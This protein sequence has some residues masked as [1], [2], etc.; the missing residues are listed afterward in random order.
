MVP[1]TLRLVEGKPYVWKELKAGQASGGIDIRP[2]DVVTAV[3]GQPIR[4][5]VEAWRPY[6]SASNE[7][8]LLRDLYRNLLRGSGAD[9]TVT[10]N[11]DNEHLQ[12]I[13][14]L[15]QDALIDQALASSH[16]REGGSFQIIDGEIAYL[17]LSTMS[18][19]ELSEAIRHS[20]GMNG[21]I[22]DIRGY[23]KTF[24]VFSLVQHLVAVNTP[25]AVF[26]WPDINRPGQFFWSGK[27]SIEPVAP[28][29]T[30]SLVI[31]VDEVT[32]SQ[33]EYTAMALKAVPKSIVI[34]SETAGADGDVSE[35]TL[36][37]GERTTFSGMGVFYPDKTQTQ[38][39]GIVADIV[40]A[41]TI[42]GLRDNRDEALEAAIR[43]IRR[44]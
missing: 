6:Y 2:G 5:I 4:Q 30:G 23:P 26:T 44:E 42:S 39:T 27:I 37:G 17:K 35:I 20:V 24:V 34:G 21:I 3:N 1:V 40:A 13:V 31:L 36:P 15:M 8:A 16:D 32:Q 9:I 43:I 33:G 19:T 7:S 29:L 12:I 25:F 38:Q 14:P 18:S 10:V 11:R 41:P 22:V 28:T